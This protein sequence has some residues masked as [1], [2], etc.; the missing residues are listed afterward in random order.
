MSTFSYAFAFVFLLSVLIFVH[1]LGH[2]LV[3]KA[4]GVRVL[5]FSLGF[6]PTIGLGRFRLSWR[7]GPTEY[8]IA[9]FPLGGFVKMLGENP[10]EGE[11]PELAAHPDEALGSRPTWQKLAIVFAGPTMNLLLPVLVF[12]GTL[13]VG[14][15]RP[16]PV[17]GMV[18]P[19]SPASQAG[20]E[21]GD[22]ILAV[23]GEPV[24]WWDQVDDAV[25]AAA[26]RT[27][28]L[29]LERAGRTLELPLAVVARPGFDEF[30]QVQDVGWSGLRFPRLRA[31]LGIPDEGTPGFAAGLR[32]GDEVVAVDGAPVDDWESFAAAYAAAHQGA[33]R[34]E[35]HR[36]DPPQT[37]QVQVPAL[38]DVAALGAVPASALVSYVRPG[39]P[40]DRA[41]L[42]AG[43]LL[44][45]VN[46]GP[47]RSFES[48][49]D[50]VQTGG[51]HP[52]DL[53]VT[54]D[55]QRREVRVTPELVS[56]DV[57]LGI[58][59]PRYMVGIAADPAVEVGALGL[60]QERNPLRALPRAVGMTV[61]VTRTFLAGLGKVLTGEVSRRQ[62]A[63]PIGIAEIA[64]RAFQ[65]GWET[66]LSIMVLISV[67]LGILN[68]LPIPIL[69]GGQALI[70]AVEG[71][72]R[73]PLSLRTREI[74]QQI[75]FTVLVLLMGLA[76]WNDLSRHWSKLLEWLSG[77]SGL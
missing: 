64:G 11:D 4:C 7:K 39:S 26:G 21:P 10:E 25:R 15:P 3:A 43:D 33:V 74:F 65:R 40:A 24:H 14:I 34:L 22:R 9:W 47:L 51:G 68:L 6:G 58:Q 50:T 18:E 27:L 37:L 8:V 56:T 41:G 62:I 38:G 45:M 59:E 20:V 46:G 53:V 17:V 57:G 67:N 52:L 44:L 42:Q 77:G 49:R 55:G 35:L 13:A 23:A 48:F 76:F 32:S 73:A 12:V 29:E 2:F 16:A 72:R 1:E 19:A 69:D 66:Y 54:R 71:V 30:G 70:F 63:G 75:G 31:M 5:K 28:H 61:D 60:D 36:G